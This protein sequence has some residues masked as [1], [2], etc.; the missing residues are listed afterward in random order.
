MLLATLA[1]TPLQCII[2]TAVGVVTLPAVLAI[3]SPATFRGLAKGA[4]RWID[5][6]AFIA[7]LDRPIDIDSHVLP[8]SRLLGAAVLASITA[9][10]FVLT[11]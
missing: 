6:S 10:G 3:V 8:H 7:K 11:R 5:T 1:I 2:G 4:N 9:L